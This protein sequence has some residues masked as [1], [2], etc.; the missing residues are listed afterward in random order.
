MRANEMQHI[1]LAAMALHP[2]YEGN[3]PVSAKH[4]REWIFD[5]K[6]IQAHTCFLTTAPAPVRDGVFQELARNTANATKS[7]PNMAVA[8]YIVSRRAR[9]TPL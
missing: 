6:A 2:D 4:T 7:D 5:P 3:V 1:A 9:Y 8:A